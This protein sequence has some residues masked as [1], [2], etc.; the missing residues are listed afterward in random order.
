MSCI[1]SLTLPLPAYCCCLTLVVFVLS[2]W[3]NLFCTVTLILVFFFC[4]LILTEYLNLL[5]FFVTFFVYVFLPTLIMTLSPLWT[6]LT[7]P[8]TLRLD[9]FTLLMTMVGLLFLTFTVV[10]TVARRYEDVMVTGVPIL[11]SGIAISSQPLESFLVRVCLPELFLLAPAHML[12]GAVRA[13]YYDGG[14]ASKRLRCKKFT[15]INL[16]RILCSHC[17]EKSSKT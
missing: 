12:C 14:R 13:Q 3:L 2:F 5:L 6:F 9:G 15:S 1:C 7:Q 4:F 8:V 17:H 11:Q 16:I 10:V